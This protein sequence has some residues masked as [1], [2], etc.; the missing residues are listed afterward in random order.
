MHLTIV[1][2]YRFY[3]VVYF[4]GHRLTDKWQLTAL[5]TNISALAIELIFR[6][7]LPLYRSYG[8]D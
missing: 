5:R 4:F 7:F 8:R 3:H 6:S 1:T 2:S